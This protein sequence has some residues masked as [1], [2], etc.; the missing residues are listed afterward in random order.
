M[1]WNKKLPIESRP[2]D[3]TFIRSLREKQ[4]TIERLRNLK[5]SPEEISVYQQDGTVAQS[6]SLVRPKRHF[7]LAVAALVAITLGG[8]VAV[9][10]DQWSRKKPRASVIQRMLRIHCIRGRLLLTVKLGG[11][12]SGIEPVLNTQ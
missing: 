8:C 4:Q 11:L 10:Q 6:V 7:L 2:S 5:V 1:P 9:V 12:S 3:D